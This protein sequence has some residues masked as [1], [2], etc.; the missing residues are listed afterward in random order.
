MEQGNARA[1]KKQ[2]LEFL[3]LLKQCI[4]II[5]KNCEKVNPRQ[6]LEDLSFKNECS[7][8]RNAESFF[9]NTWVQYKRSV[10]LPS[11]IKCILCA[12]LETF[13]VSYCIFFLQTHKVYIVNLT[14]QMQWPKQSRAVPYLSVTATKWQIAYSDTTCFDNKGWAQNLHLIV[15]CV[16][17]MLL[18]SLLI[19][20]VS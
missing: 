7:F 12:K 3:M 13:S 2:Y 19:L 1:R 20:L 5:S 11:F 6:M 17:S 18:S 14:L 9:I 10:S 15:L 4:R 16:T 8:L